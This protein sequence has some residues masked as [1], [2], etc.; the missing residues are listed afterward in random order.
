MSSIGVQAKMTKEFDAALASIHSDYVD[1]ASAA[2]DSQSC[3]RK[4]AAIYDNTPGFRSLWNFGMLNVAV[5]AEIR[6]LVPDYDAYE[7]DGYSEQLYYYTLRQ[8]PRGEQPRKVLEIGCG[9]GGGLNFLSRL[10]SHSEFVGL[11]LS[12]NAIKHANARFG[13]PGKLAYVHGD[14]EDLPFPA[15]EF[16]LVINVESSHNYPSL[17]KFLRE[18]ARVLKPGGHLSLVDVFTR[19]RCVFMERCKH[20]SADT[21]KWL[22]EA[23]ILEDVK[24][25]VRVRMDP[26]SKFRM[27]RRQSLPLP[28]RLLLEPFEIFAFGSFLVDSK[29]GYANRLYRWSNSRARESRWGPYAI[30]SYR[31]YLARRT[32][33]DTRLV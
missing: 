2:V 11:D 18:V 12:K 32:G 26:K 16:D 6:A 21:F 23:D 15:Q 19:D 1:R 3:K 7:S 24:A 17:P 4:I 13:R 14:A 22:R 8:A 31:H 9:Q 29:S 20:G 10:E 30:D 33:A 28:H 5:D 25:A 27:H